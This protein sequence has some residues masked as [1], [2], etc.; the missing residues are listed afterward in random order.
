MTEYV[1]LPTLILNVREAAYTAGF[2][3]GDPSATM[4]EKRVAN[5]AYGE[6]IGAVT[7][8]LTELGLL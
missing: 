4:E 5:L 2:I 7:A 8:R 1:G 6:A 3:N